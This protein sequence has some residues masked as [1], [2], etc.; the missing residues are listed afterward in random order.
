MKKAFF[1]IDDC[2]IIYIDLLNRQYENIFE[3]KIFRW[4]Q[5]LH[6]QLG[7]KVILY[8]V[9]NLSNQE[10]L[11]AVLDKYRRDFADNADWLKIGIH[12]FRLYENKENG[13]ESFV[14]RYQSAYQSVKNKMGGVILSDILRVHY[15]FLTTQ[16]RNVVRDNGIKV[17]LTAD[18]DR[19]SYELPLEIVEKINNYGSFQYEGLTFQRTDFRIERFIRHPFSMAKLLHNKSVTFFTH[20]QYLRKIHYRIA[21]AMVCYFLKKKNYEFK[22]SI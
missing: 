1:S 9:W 4:L 22:N 3:N 8:S 13:A 17:L 2:R 21:T 7:I 19:I 15:F 18:D 11:L 14:N 12:C 10:T 5:N 6:K 16:G 20:E